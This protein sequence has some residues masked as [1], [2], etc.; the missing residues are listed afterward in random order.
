MLRTDEQIKKDVVDQMYWDSRIDAGAI[1]T[2]VV[3]GTV[4]LKGSVDSYFGKTV[5]GTDAQSVQGVRQVDNQLRIR[6]TKPA[7]AR[8]E[9]LDRVKK[10]LALHS[11]V[12]LHQLRVFMDGD[13]LF[14]EGVVDAYWKKTRVEELAYQV[15][16]V[17]DV[18]NRIGVAPQARSADEIIAR[19]V[20]DALRRRDQL[21]AET[22]DVKVKEGRV[23]L[24]GTVPTWVARNSAYEAALYTDGVVEVEED[25]IVEEVY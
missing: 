11:E 3:D 17:T 6:S 15:E 21:A 8:E 9:I 1:E 18:E 24:S 16:G 13:A 12:N 23:R 5:A 22:V 7:A 20:V 2:D 14:I 4:V 19:N 10:V 25:L